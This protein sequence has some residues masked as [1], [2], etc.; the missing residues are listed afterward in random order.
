MKG[1]KGE[2]KR[3]RFTNPSPPT[4]SASGTL[5]K[6]E[7]YIVLMY[8]AFY[9]IAENKKK[10]IPWFIQFWTVGLGIEDCVV[11]MCGS[12]CKV[13]QIFSWLVSPE[14]SLLTRWIRF[15]GTNVRSNWGCGS[16][17]LCWAVYLLGYHQLGEELIA[18]SNCDIRNFSFRINYEFD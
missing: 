5:Q 16:Y 18:H 9:L 7:I 11:M 8:F 1:E 12:D 3:K 14:G 2:R 17:R 10:I 4:R 6:P 15:D 13:V